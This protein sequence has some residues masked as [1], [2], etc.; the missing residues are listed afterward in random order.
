M[1]FNTTYDNRVDYNLLKTNYNVDEKTVLVLLSTY[2]R[3]EYIIET[4][5]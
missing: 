3:M 1:I 2:N 5:E 4:I